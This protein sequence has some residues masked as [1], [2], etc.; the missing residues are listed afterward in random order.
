MDPLE[1]VDI[2]PYPDR[3]TAARK[4]TGFNDA[5][6]C[7]TAFIKGRKVILS[8]MDFTFLGGSMGSVVERRSPGPPRPRPRKTFH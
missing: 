1:F 6:H 5:V 3:I 2:K 8:V 4:K 7:G